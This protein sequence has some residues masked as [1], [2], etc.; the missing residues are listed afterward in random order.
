MKKT[1][2]L[3]VSFWGIVSAQNAA[4]SSYLDPQISGNADVR[5]REVR[6]PSSGYSICTYWCTLGYWTSGSTHGYGGLQWTTDN[7]QGPKN[8]IYSQWN[9]YSTAAYHDPA[10]QVKTFGGEGTGVKSINN[11]PLNEWQPDFWHV[12]A[13][14]VW[15]EGN[16]SHFAFIVKDG[17]TGIWRHIITWSTPEANLRFTGSYCFIE[18]WRGD[19]EYRESQIR[20]GW[21]RSSS[22]ENWTPLTTYKYNINDGDIAPGGR[23]YNKRTNWCGG[24]KSDATG[25]F[26]Y[27]GA[28]GFVACTN[29]DNTNYTIARTETSPQQEYGVHRISDLK[30]TMF[31]GDNKL[32]VH[33]NWDST[34]VPQYSYSIEIKDGNTTVLTK[35]DTIPEKRAD[36]L[37]ISSLSPSS[38]GYSVFLEIVDFFDGKSD[39]KTV[40]FGDGSVSVYDNLE[41]SNRKISI[42]NQGEKTIIVNPQFNN[43]WNF[44]LFSLN[45]KLLYSQKNISDSQIILNNSL[46]SLSSGVYIFRIDNMNRI[47]NIR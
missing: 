21:N 12:T 3:L 28:G 33:W 2:L 39:P 23:S 38:K 30:A 14:R 26:F 42:I 32:A 20:K 5:I 7:S 34:T 22:T 11:D 46:R 8:H 17:E 16:N 9:D 47:V 19:G 10:T 31:E 4:V 15:S 1:I 27:M 36:T 41:R 43:N 29:N 24:I 40:T 25:D 18:D 35:S 44:K 45:G 37:D 6:V 13:D